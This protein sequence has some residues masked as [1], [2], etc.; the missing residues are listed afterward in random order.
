METGLGL[1]YDCEVPSRYCVIGVTVNY[2]TSTRLSCGLG[3]VGAW[4]PAL[5]SQRRR[6]SEF[7]PEFAWGM[8]IRY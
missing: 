5:Q 3:C 2:M 6:N 1:N 7:R 8:I 4:E